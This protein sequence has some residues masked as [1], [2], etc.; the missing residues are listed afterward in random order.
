LDFEWKKINHEK[1][2]VATCGGGRWHGGHDKSGGGF[3]GEVVK[4]RD[5]LLSGNLFL[6]YEFT[7]KSN[8]TTPLN[9][10]GSLAT[11]LSVLKHVFSVQK[12]L[13]GVVVLSYI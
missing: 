8:I 5:Q 12:Q 13:C 4:F 2:P 10:F 9:H 1:T 3:L 11:P 6:H 7:E